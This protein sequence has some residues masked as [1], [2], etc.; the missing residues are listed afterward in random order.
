MND[1]WGHVLESTVPDLVLDV[2]KG[3]D[4]V[5][6]LMTATPIQKLA[7]ARRLVQFSAN[8]LGTLVSFAKDRE[9][10]I[11]GIEFTNQTAENPQK[12]QDK[13]AL[14]HCVALDRHPWAALVVGIV[15]PS[16]MFSAMKF[17]NDAASATNVDGNLYRPVRQLA[18][19]CKKGKTRYGY[20]LTDM[21]LS[22][23]YFPDLAEGAETRPWF[24]P[25]PFT[26]W[27]E[28][29]LTTDLAIWWLCMMSMEATINQ[30]A[31]PYPAV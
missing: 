8:Y 20:I 7:D 21:E 6:L 31:A 2:V 15:R 26:S 25:I 24:K 30:D 17:A 29:Q 12:R 1:R 27:G 3:Q 22:V 28:G 9:G 11:S 16:Y 10:L 23:W 18:N 14:D 19:L 13:T 5:P 4:P